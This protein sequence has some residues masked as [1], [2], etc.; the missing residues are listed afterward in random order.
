VVV[1]LD[2]F[3]AINDAHGHHAGDH[4]LR[5]VARSWQTTTRGGGDLMARLGGDEFGLLA[6]ELVGSGG[7]QAA[8][9]L[10][11]ALPEGVSASVG[12]ATWD[13]VER[14]SGLLRRADRAMY[15]SKRRRHRGGYPRPA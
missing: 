14:A 5:A 9:R 11:E 10:I 2:N 6:P 1:D 7:E 13:R 3:K 12:V 15:H 8:R 4:V